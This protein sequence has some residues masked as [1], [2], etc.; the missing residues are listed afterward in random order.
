MF[1]LSLLAFNSDWMSLSW[2]SKQFKFPENQNLILIKSAFKHNRVRQKNNSTVSSVLV[3][4]FKFLS[5]L[6]AIKNL[7]RLFCISS[8]IFLSVTFSSTSPTFL[9]YIILF[10]VFY[11]IFKISRFRFETSSQS[12]LFFKNYLKSN[13]IPYLWIITI[14][15][16]LLSHGFIDLIENQFYEILFISVLILDFLVGTGMKRIFLSELIWIYEIQ[17]SWESIK[18]LEYSN[19]NQTFNSNI[20]FKI[21]SKLFKLSTQEIH[22]YLDK[23]DFN[24]LYFLLKLNPVSIDLSKEL[25]TYLLTNV[26]LNWLLNEISEFIKRTHQTSFEGKI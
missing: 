8:A 1:I 20:I 16:L 24:R 25:H 12:K 2:I 22:G 11:L 6:I 15:I 14:Q 19:S 13:Y 21:Q 7:L 3:M 26:E 9:L 18:R 23:D 5:S 10:C 17:A 4:P